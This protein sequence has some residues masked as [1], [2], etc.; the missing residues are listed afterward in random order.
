MWSPFGSMLRKISPGDITQQMSLP[1]QTDFVDCSDGDLPFVWWPAQ[2]P[3]RCSHRPT[4]RRRFD[5]RAVSRAERE[6]SRPRG[7]V[8]CWWRL[9]LVKRTAHGFFEAQRVD[10]A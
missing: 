3:I 7:M 10:L 2:R 6:M 8:R 9:G 5:G 1:W 4:T